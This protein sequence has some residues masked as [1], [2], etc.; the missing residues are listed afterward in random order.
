MNEL[1]AKPQENDL[2]HTTHSEDIEKDRIIL[3][4][5]ESVERDETQTQRKLAAELGIALGLVNI[6]LK[7]CVKKGLV[8]ISEA[9]ARRY[10]YYLTPKGL[11]E[12]SRLTISYLSYSF[13]FFRRARAD[14]A[15]VF[16]NQQ[17]NGW[18]RFVLAG[19]SDLAEIAAICALERGLEIVA[20]V[21]ANAT[22]DFSVGRPV[23]PSFDAVDGN[24]DCIIVTDL[25]TP[26][27]TF[28]AAVRLLGPDRVLIP[29]LLG[30]REP[31]KAAS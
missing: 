27:A 15:L 16:A 9:P 26:R 8:K 2:S 20:V 10:A 3:G 29:N 7:R 28:D 12:K 19:A 22:A 25:K 23:V 13:G 31:A 24:F 17:T 30:V 21:D 5:L 6:Y 11:S 4:L 14:C 18:K 1:K